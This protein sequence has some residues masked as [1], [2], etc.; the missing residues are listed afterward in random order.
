MRHGPRSRRVAAALTLIALLAAACPPPP[1]APAAAAAPSDAA[2]TLPSTGVFEPVAAQQAAR[3][4]RLDR[5]KGKATAERCMLLLDLGQVDQAREMLGSLRGSA[6]DV[7]LAR[8]RV[9]LTC[10]DFAAARPLIEAMAARRDPSDAERRLRFGWLFALDD[11][12]RVDSLT[13]GALLAPDAGARL[14]ELLAAGRLAYDLLDYARAESCFARVLERTGEAAPAPDRAPSFADAAR[15]EALAGLGNVR[16]KRRDYDGSFAKLKAS[17][18]AGA[19]PDA[20]VAMAET[21]I[22]LGRTDEGIGAARWAVALDPYHE[23]GHYYLGNG[24]TRKSYTELYPAYPAAFADSAGRVALA[25]ADSLLAAG[26]RAGARAAYEAVRAAHPGWADARARLASLDFE[27]DRFDDARDRCFAALQLC[28]EYGRAHAALAK[29]LESQRFAVDVHRPGYERRF[30]AAPMPDV[31]GI[32]SF[33]LNWKSLSPRHQK[34]VALSVA[35]WKQFLPVLVEGGATYYIKPLYQLLSETPG[36]ETLHDQ[37]IDYDSRLWDD[38]RGAGGYHT[39][40]GV[41]DVERTIFD[42]YNTVLHE[43]THQVHAVLTA[44]QSREIQEHYRRAKER[45]AASRNAFL[46]RYAGGSVWEYFAEGANALESPKRDAYD[47]REVVRERLD[48]MDPDLRELVKR[49]MALTDVSAS[50]PVAYVNAGDDRVERGQVGAAVPFYEKALQRAPTEETALQAMTRA[51]TYEGAGARAVAA[52]DSARAAHPASGPVLVTS[53]DAYWRAARGIGAA[54]WMLEQG[55]P[56]VRAEDRYLVDLE[57]GHLY[58]T[59]GDAGRAL[60]AFE[61]VL[62]YQADNPEGLWGKA[63]ALALAARWDEAFPIYDQAVRLRTGVVGL[64]C[65]F[66]RD[67]LRAGHLAA[68]RTQLAEAALLDPEHPEAEALRGWVAMEAGQPDSART[69][70]ERAL[71]WGEWCDLARLLLGRLEQQAGRTA[72]AEAAWAPVRERLGTEAPP[73]YVYRPK[74]ARW[75]SVHELPALERALLETR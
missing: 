65:D 69:H 33:V 54:L 14:P 21:L 24:Y 19:T 71:A 31:P 12:A 58:W 60:A 59:N 40:T 3:M 38:V 20:L 1:A 36:L 18:E 25:G 28:P 29:A 30:A 53:A 37:R 4:A 2:L 63:A 75:E 61:S 56:G 49:L 8:A 48:A 68:A 7:A 10:Q 46:S 11:A 17:L 70:L 62:A 15:A 41:E 73:G 27:E 39:V 32:E 6:R 22:R 55:R 13:G 50:Y 23:Q 16:Y 42:R 44:D 26:D 45:D 47:P 5:L 67:L 35:P 9:D 51:L 43:L 64:R 34:R 74:L 72:E 52:A 66:A 57:L